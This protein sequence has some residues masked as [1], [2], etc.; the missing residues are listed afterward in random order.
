M[1]IWWMRIRR[2]DTGRRRMRGWRFGDRRFRRIF[3]IS[4]GS[5]EGMGREGRGRHKLKLTVSGMGVES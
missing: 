2:L 3:W 1:G 5:P 4:D